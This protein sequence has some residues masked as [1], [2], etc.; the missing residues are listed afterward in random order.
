MLRTELLA[1]ATATCA[2]SSQ[3]LS[4][5]RQHLDH[6]QHAHRKRG[7]L[8]LRK[9]QKKGEARS[10]GGKQHQIVKKEE[11]A[12]AVA[13]CDLD[14]TIIRSGRERLFEEDRY[15]SVFPNTDPNFYLPRYWLLREVTSCARG[16]PARGYTKWM[17]LN[18]MWSELS[19]LLR[20]KRVSESFIK[21]C[22][23]PQNYKIMVPLDRAINMV[24]LEALRYYRQNRGTGETQQDIS[25]F[26]KNRRNLHRLF[27][28]HWKATAHTHRMRFA[29]SLEQIHAA[30]EA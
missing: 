6:F 4:G 8:Y 5:F 23:R 24:Y 19:P 9:R 13:G 30:L 22:E 2:A 17:V 18:F 28:K 27:P 15:S 25:I 3:P 26:F 20:S 16:A 21:A 11:L 7:Y 1:L 10:G 29:A 14:P 12:Q